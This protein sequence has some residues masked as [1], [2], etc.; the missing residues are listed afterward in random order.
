MHRIIFLRWLL[1]NL[2]G[3]MKQELL[4]N[5]I[6]IRVTNSD[7]AFIEQHISQSGLSISDLFRE[8]IQELK[9]SSR[10]TN[11]K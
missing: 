3:N 5:F 1:L 9:N 7:R 2:L 8:L 10:G 11:P 4:E 6:R